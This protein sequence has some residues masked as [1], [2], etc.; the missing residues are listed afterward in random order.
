MRIV[1]RGVKVHHFHIVNAT[2]I[3]VL[4]ITECELMTLCN[5]RK[6]VTI[7]WNCHEA[8]NCDISD[9]SAH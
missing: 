3:V 8:R 1:E 9:H 2:K 6:C 7:A 5:S 4:V